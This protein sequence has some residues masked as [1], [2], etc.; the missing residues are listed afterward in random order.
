MLILLP[1]MRMPP[2]L[3]QMPLMADPSLEEKSAVVQSL[4]SEAPSGTCLRKISA[5]F[6]L[7]KGIL[8]ELGS[9]SGES[10]PCKGP[11]VQTHTDSYIYFSNVLIAP[12]YKQGKKKKTETQ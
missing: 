12:I 9:L 5:A 6:Q 4:T 1:Q 7:A 8:T 11:A 10:G 2:Q 3:L